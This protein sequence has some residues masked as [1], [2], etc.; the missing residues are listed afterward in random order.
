MRGRQ[1]T[2]HPMGSEPSQKNAV[3]MPGFSAQRRY[4]R[5]FSVAAPSASAGPC[6]IGQALQTLSSAITSPASSVWHH[7]HP[8]QG[9]LPQREAE[10]VLV[11]VFREDSMH[12]SLC[13]GVPW[14]SSGIPSIFS[15]QKDLRNKSEVRHL[16]SQ[17]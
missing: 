4:L 17:N 5:V 1:S 7:R 15:L 3:H 16:T 6:P 2:N 14:D 10:Y 9:V 12:S 13:P 11:L 8:H